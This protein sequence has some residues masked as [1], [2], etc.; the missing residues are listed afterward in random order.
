MSV[1]GVL[2]MGLSVD[3]VVGLLVGTVVEVGNG[4][5]VKVGFG[6]IGEVA[7]GTSI[8]ESAATC[9]TGAQALLMSKTIRKRIVMHF[10]GVPLGDELSC[11]FNGNF[12]SLVPANTEG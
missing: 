4:V 2:R 3:V 10:M 7:I 1:G 8:S 9:A 11:C 5:V 6:R 12:Y